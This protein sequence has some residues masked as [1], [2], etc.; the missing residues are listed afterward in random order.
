MDK[1]S[2]TEYEEVRVGCFPTTAHAVA[3][4]GGVALL[5]FTSLGAGN[6]KRSYLDF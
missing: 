1:Y 5:V 6:Y 2:R 4:R 3:S